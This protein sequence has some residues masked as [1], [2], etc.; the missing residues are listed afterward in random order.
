VASAEALAIAIENESPRVGEFA[1]RIASSSHQLSR[2]VTDLLDLSRLESASMPA[3]RVLL[4]RVAKNEMEVIADRF[5]ARGVELAT[6]LD[7][8]TVTGSPA[9]LGL[10]I[11]NLLENALAYTDSGGQ[12]LLRIEK[13]GDTAVIEVEDSGT[14]IPSRSIDRVFERF[15]R[16][17]QARSRQTGGTG[18][19]LAIV[20]HVAEAHGGSVSVTSELGMGSVFRI[21][22]PCS[23]R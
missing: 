15:Y 3:E 5:R 23:S 22:I 7:R 10:A 19:G 6:A 12:V 4:Q 14:G 17:D 2:I 21:E 20:K 9:D 13:E 16:V 8:V 1:G 11:R 18:L